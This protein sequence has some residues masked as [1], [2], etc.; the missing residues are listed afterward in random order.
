MVK[1]KKSKYEKPRDIENHAEEVYVYEDTEPYYEDSYFPKRKS[2]TDLRH[3]AGKRSQKLIDKGEQ[4][5]PVSSNTRQ[6]TKTFWGKSWSKNLESYSDYETRLP[7]GRSYLRNGSV[8]D[9]KISRGL[10]TALV[11]GSEL[12]EIS[13]TIKKL[14]DKRWQEIIRGCSGN[15]GGVLELM[16]GKLSE[17]VMGHIT[18]KQHGLFPNPKE[19]T[20]NC[21]CLDWADMCKHLAAVLYGV[22]VRLDGEPSLFFTLRGVEYDEL[23]HQSGQYLAKQLDSSNVEFNKEELE[24]LFGIEISLPSK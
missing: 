23:I 15:I 20:M 22:G 16:S 12:Y 5:S 8:I 17:E 2:V 3:D 18:D 13:I 24:S 11:S 10:I 14:N 6:I 9:L 21:N 4:L 19:I 1:R 7:R